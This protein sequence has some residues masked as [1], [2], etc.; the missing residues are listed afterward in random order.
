MIYI[1][2]F[3]KL[4]VNI[5][6]L[7]IIVG[8]LYYKKKQYLIILFK[9]NK[10]SKIG[11]YYIILPFCPFNYFQVNDKKKFLCNIKKIT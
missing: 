1:I 2:N 5:A 7:Y 10:G 11:F 8:K 3:K 4:V 6:I 9:V